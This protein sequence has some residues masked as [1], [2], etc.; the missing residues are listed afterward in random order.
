MVVAAALTRLQEE[1]KCLDEL[2]DPITIE[3][4]HNLCRSCIQQSWADPQDSF[5]CPVC[6][7]QDSFLC[8]VCCHQC[9]ERHYRS[10]TQ[11][12][13]TI[14][15]AKLLH[16]SM[17]KRQSQDQ[18]SLCE[19]HNE[20]LTPF[21]EEDLELLCSLCAGPPD[22][23]G[24]YMRPIKEAASYHRGMLENYIKP[25]KRQVA[26]VQKLIS[27]QGNKRIEL[28]ET[29]EPSVRLFKIFLHFKRKLPLFLLSTS[30]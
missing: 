12:G 11:L 20:V 21:C 15:I 27:I 23:Q 29:L 7:H 22:Y 24:H 8:P 5:P 30:M 28:R 18:M 3:C 26:D 14:E 25:L 6:C 9:K 1:V 4:G 19:K 13:R 10:N 17:R 2:K 16:L